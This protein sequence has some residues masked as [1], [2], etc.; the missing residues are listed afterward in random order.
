MIDILGLFFGNI[1]R[2]IS[3]QQKNTNRIVG[4]LLIRCNMTAV[5]LVGYPCPDSTQPAFNH[6]PLRQSN[7]YGPLLRWQPG[8]NSA[9]KTILNDITSHHYTH[10]KINS[11][12]FLKYLQNSFVT[13][14]NFKLLV[15]RV[16]SMNEHNQK[17]T[18]RVVGN[19]TIVS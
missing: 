15:G 6:K 5:Q 19:N 3:K 13:I 8:G 17:Q 12:P 7:E 11:T 16:C 18:M 1:A 10:H 4:R 2:K 9:I 14:Q